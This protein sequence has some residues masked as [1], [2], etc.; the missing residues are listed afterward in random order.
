M[1]ITVTVF[2]SVAE[3]LTA[4][5]QSLSHA[6]LFVTLWTVARQSLSMGFPRQ[7]YSSGLPFPSS[8][9]LPNPGI[10]FSASPALAGGFFTTE[11][12]EKPRNIEYIRFSIG[13]I[14]FLANFWTCRLAASFLFVTL[15]GASFFI[16][17]PSGFW[18]VNSLLSVK[19]KLPVA[20]M[21]FIVTLNTD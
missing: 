13:I 18:K 1:R 11:P 6:W 21:G 4:C 12:P 9:D 10:E 16:R 14:A 20:F 7:E 5:V 3:T 15:M 2:K 17:S 8:G 19:K